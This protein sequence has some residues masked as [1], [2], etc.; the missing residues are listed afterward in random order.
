MRYY[1]ETWVDSILS[2]EFSPFVEYKDMLYIHSVR[3]SSARPNWETAT[4]KLISQVDYLVV[5]ESIVPFWDP[6]TEYAFELTHGF[7]FID[8]RIDSTSICPI[9]LEWL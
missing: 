1:S 7:T 8:G 9:W 4:H 5:V 6:E 2:A 3:M